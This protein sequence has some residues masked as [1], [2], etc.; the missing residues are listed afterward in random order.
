MADIDPKVQRALNALRDPEFDPDD[1]EGKRAKILNDPRVRA[2]AE[3][4]RKET[5]GG[6]DMDPEMLLGA[7]YESRYNRKKQK[8]AEAKQS[9]IDS[10][11][12]SVSAENP[13][14]PMQKGYSE[15]VRDIAHRVSPVDAEGSP[16]FDLDLYDSKNIDRLKSAGDPQAADLASV[17]STGNKVRA[18]LLGG[19]AGLA[20]GPLAPATVLGSGMVGAGS[21]AVSGAAEGVGAGESA[22]DVAKRT[23]AG[24]VSG[25]LLGMLFGLPAAA[26]RHLRAHPDVGEDIVRAETQGY[27]TQTPLTGGGMR[28]PG[29]EQGYRPLRREASQVAPDVEKAV[30]AMDES[31]AAKNE[32]GRAAALGTEESAKKVSSRPVLD[33]YARLIKQGTF[34]DGTPIPESIAPR[35]REHVK[36]LARMR[37]VPIEQAEAEAA[38]TGGVSMPL[39]RLSGADGPKALG[40]VE[41]VPEVPVTGGSRDITP[42]PRKGPSSLV[43]GEEVEVPVELGPGGRPVQRG[44]G[45]RSANILGPNGRLAE[46]PASEP[47]QV[48]ESPSFHV[49]SDGEAVP[50]SPETSLSP[51]R[52]VP[53]GT[54]PRG[55]AKPASNPTGTRVE[56]T[57][58]E[59]VPP[60]EAHRYA[61]VM[62][63]RQVNARELES[64]RNTMDDVGGAEQ[65]VASPFKALSAKAREVRSQ[66]YPG[67]EKAMAAEEQRVGDIQRVKAATPSR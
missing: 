25:G 55:Y 44:G 64:F 60:E 62:E 38:R 11:R 49:G 13:Q 21:G 5:H 14:Y 2:Y 10:E 16:S 67:V 56:Y 30:K 51:R 47:H 63:P 35:L 45:A 28:K 66:S 20:L 32:A 36:S 26:V 58:P 4:V 33:E 48:G 8:D 23:G 61:V 22:G 6:A 50:I 7:D 24:A 53:S 3:Q 54:G 34:D 17:R 59:H 46:V 18:G 37:V 52:P 15:D 40:A 42:K 9:A 31:I 19:A 41:D 43:P 1:R 12:K 39:R 57:A 29:V 65:R 27:T